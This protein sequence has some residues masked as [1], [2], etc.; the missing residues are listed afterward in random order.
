MKRRGAPEAR[1]GFKASDAGVPARSAASRLLEGVLRGKPLDALLDPAEGDPVF[2]GLEPRNRA[3]ARAVVATTLR[4]RGQIKAALQRLMERGVPPRSG[5]L[6]SILEIAAAQ[7]LFLEVPDYAAVS[8]A[9]ADAEADRHAGHYKSL[10]NG[11]LR[12]LARERDAIL[13]AQ[14][15]ERI[16]TPEWLWQRWTMHFGEAT[17]RKIAAAHLLDPNLDLTT[18][19]DAASWAERLGGMVLSKDTVRLVA[20]GPIEDLP[21]YAEG[22]W[23]VQNAAAAIP[24]RLFGDVTGKRVADLCAAPG[25]KTAALAV[26]G[27]EVTAVDI[28]AG[29]LERVAANLA[30]LKLGAKLVAADALAWQPSEP[31]DAVLLDAPCTATGTI[32]RHPDIPWLKRPEDI[33]SLAELQARLIA[34]AVAMLKP[35]GTLFYCTCSLE[36]EEGEKHFARLLG[37]HD[38]QLVP[39]QPGE[40]GGLAEA[41][42]PEGAV[43]TLPS[44]LAAAEP[45]LSGLDGFFIV[46]LQKRLRKG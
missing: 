18:K 43:R 36:P 25:G 32:R 1:P 28:S 15:A 42:T 8:T 33:A 24:A 30:R 34:R 2:R 45:R 38:L 35:G 31:F 7:I 44:Q 46:R 11:V 23:W 27:A 40:L 10:L 20:S 22:D 29:R 4:R 26:A 39:V 12:R 19:G 9:M 13:G 37:E 6:A 16:N 5:R 17:T 21:G 3:L 41:V 14:D